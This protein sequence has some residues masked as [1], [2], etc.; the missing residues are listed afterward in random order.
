[1]NDRETIFIRAKDGAG[2]EYFCPFDPD[3][4]SVFTP[5]TVSE[6]CVEESTVGRYA[7]R[8]IVRG[9]SIDA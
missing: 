6:D 1:M 7:G 3:M 4:E 5:P 9:Q 8:L 2:N